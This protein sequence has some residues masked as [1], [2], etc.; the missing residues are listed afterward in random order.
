MRL[1]HVGMSFFIFIEDRHPT[2]WGAS[3]SSQVGHGMDL[4]KMWRES[5]P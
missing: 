2:G 1:T 3:S 5:V 4:R